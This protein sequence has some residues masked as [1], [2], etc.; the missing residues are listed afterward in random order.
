M[1]LDDRRKM[2]QLETC[3]HDDIVQPHHPKV[4]NKKCASAPASLRSACAS[5]R[6]LTKT[7]FTRFPA[8]ATILPRFC[9]S[10]PSGAME[11]RCP[12]SLSDNHQPKP[13][14]CIPTVC[15]VWLANHGHLKELI[16]ELNTQ[17]GLSP[18]NASMGGLPHTT[19]HS[20]PRRLAKSYLVRNLHSLQSSGFCWRPCP[21]GP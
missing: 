14:P 6:K 19:H 21:R 3:T 11:K 20:G 4:Q 7:V 12:L 8:S 9:G 15:C 2:S 16:S 18:V 5:L 17:P 10:L 13:A 1:R